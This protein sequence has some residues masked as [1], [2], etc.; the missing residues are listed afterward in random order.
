M[1]TQKFMLFIWDCPAADP[2]V[3]MEAPTQELVGFFDGT[4]EEVQRFVSDQR[5][6]SFSYELATDEAMAELDSYEQS[7]ADYVPFF[8]PTDRRDIRAVL[9][10]ERA[11]RYVEY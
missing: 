9:A 6:A 1:N 11:M 3:G 5:G 8:E 7:A 4:E 10:E 2:E